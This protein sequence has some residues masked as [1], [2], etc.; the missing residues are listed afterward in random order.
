[1]PSPGPDGLIE[2]EIDEVIVEQRKISA[3]HK[4]SLCS[5][6]LSLQRMITNGLKEQDRI[7]AYR[8]DNI[9]G[10]IGQKGDKHTIIQR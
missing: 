4:L 7:S 5:T 2:P 1:M 10:E 3:S 8:V 9:R 6:A